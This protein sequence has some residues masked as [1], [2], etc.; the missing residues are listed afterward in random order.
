MLPIVRRLPDLA[1]AL[2]SDSRASERV[3]G[4]RVGRG[5]K[6]PAPV[7]PRPVSSHCAS[8]NSWRA[9]RSASSSSASVISAVHL[10][11]RA[12]AGSSFAR[13]PCSARFRN[14][15]GLV[16]RAPF[17]DIRAVPQRLVYR[18]QGIQRGFAVG[19]LL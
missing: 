6:K 10:A 17:V 15:L 1:Q 13:A 11:T 7:C 14:G 9:L 3:L 12:G 19:M 4:V 16:M 8:S 18:G 5:K 2:R